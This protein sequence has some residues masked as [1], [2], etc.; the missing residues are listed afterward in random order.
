V[1]IFS[2][3]VG[4]LAG[5]R[6]RAI[7]IGAGLYAL[8]GLLAFALPTPMGGNISRLGAEFAAP[9]LLGVRRPILGLV[10]VATLVALGTWQWL[11][12]VREASKAIG[13]PSYSARY[14][15]PLIDYL[16]RDAGGPVRIEVPLTRSHWEA[17]YLARRFPLARGWQ[18]Q[19]DVK[20]D[21]LFHRAGGV[22]SATYRAWLRR[23]AVAYV[24][25]PDAPLDPSG[26]AEGRLIRRGLPY[27]RPVWHEA[28]WRLFRVRD[29]QPLVTGPAKLVSLTS[30]RI[31]L[32]ARRA[33]TALVRVRFTPYWAI[34]TGGCV[35]RAAGGWTRVEL[36][37]AGGVVVGL[38]FS[39]SRAGRPDRTC[40]HPAR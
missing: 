32:D 17:V 29:A 9:V 40:L 13:D 5:P 38:H 21:A 24:A 31:V 6:E 33:G 10:P 20:Y 39:L 11:A 7:R 4:A 30:S 27:L 22:T 26:R 8:A 37:R 1:L 12:P 34:A 16:Q 35:A 14:Y 19:L 3:L 25:L 2:A 18:T 36:P 23:N 15:A 28:H